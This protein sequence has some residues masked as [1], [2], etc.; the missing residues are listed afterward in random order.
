MYRAGLAYVI[1]V[2]FLD[3]PIYYLC[4]PSDLFSSINEFVVRYYSRVIVAFLVVT[5]FSCSDMLA[6][7]YFVSICTMDYN[8]K[9]ESL[10]LTFKLIAHDLEMTIQETNNV[11][12]RLGSDKESPQANEIITAYINEHFQVV[13]GNELLNMQ[14][15]GK[16]TELD[17][18]LYLY[19]E[20]ENVTKVKELVI[21]NTILVHSFDEQENILH[22]NVGDVEK[23]E[24]F[25]KSIT[26]KEIKITW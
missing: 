4:A 2:T 8:Q 14:F 22:L 23:S 10:E 12:L 19:F 26:R 17:E 25:N 15:V 5:V 24:V 7:N 3:G 1:D 9:E 21:V 18:S 16:E 20:I 6:H 13:A 11:T